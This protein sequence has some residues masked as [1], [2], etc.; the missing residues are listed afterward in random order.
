MNNWDNKDSRNLFATIAKIKTTNE[1]KLF[2]RDLLTEKEIIE[3]SNRWKAAKML[4]SKISYAEISYSTG[5]S[6]RTI[7]RISRWLN[8]GMGG[9]KSML[10]GDSNAHH[11]VTSSEKGL[12]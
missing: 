7:A 5:L 4:N 9:Y 8:S 3:F 11:T 10:K 12:S 2:F 6:S 1:A